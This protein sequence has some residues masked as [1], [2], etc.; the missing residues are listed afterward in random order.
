[1]TD[2]TKPWEHRRWRGGI[3][4]S[5]LAIKS[6]VFWG[7]TT[8][9]SGIIVLLMRTAPEL[10]DFENSR[11][12][13]LV[14]GGIGLGIL[15]VAANALVST[16]RWVRFGKCFVRMHT[17]PGVIGGHFR[18][19]VML[20]DTLPLDSIVLLQLKCES[21]STI[22]GK[23][24]NS[25]TIFK[26]AEWEESIKIATGE[27]SRRNRRCTVPFDFGIPA[28]LPDE[29]DSRRDSQSSLD[30]TWL[31]RVRTQLKGPDLNMEYVVPIFKNA[32]PL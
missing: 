4:T 11:W 24:D 31:L 26:D 8:F 18:G 32:Q 3:C 21:Y 19:E 17:V 1:M 29:T 20:P 14:P 9:L 22:Y 23:N 27:C 10:F 2:N 15:I 7:I 13:L 5:D 30:F 28:G 16:I 25:D 6:V 12:L